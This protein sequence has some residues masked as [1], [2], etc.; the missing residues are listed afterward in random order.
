MNAAYWP[1]WAELTLILVYPFISLLVCTLVGLGHV[2][3]QPPS[4]ATFSSP[5][6][7]G[8][9]HRLLPVNL[10]GPHPGALSL[11]CG[12]DLLMHNDRG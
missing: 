12:Y 8:F 4:L 1:I 9:L 5:L 6:P 7:R 3:S 2:S 10:L 11:L